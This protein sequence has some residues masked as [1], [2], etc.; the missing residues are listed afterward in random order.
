[1]NNNTNNANTN[2]PLHYDYTSTS[3]TDAL[4]KLKELR[5]DKNIEIYSTKEIT[6]DDFRKRKD[7]D[8]CIFYPDCGGIFDPS[9]SVIFK[10]ESVLEYALNNVSVEDMED[11][12]DYCGPH[13]HFVR[14][15]KDTHPRLR[16]MHRECYRKYKII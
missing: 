6:E 4:E 15:T 5:G 8:I 9:I 13:Q 3:L 12:E 2:N 7:N 14:D 10:M 16:K 11:V 1:M